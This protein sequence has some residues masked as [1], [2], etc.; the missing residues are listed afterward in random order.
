MPSARP[1]AVS[2]EFGQTVAEIR[3]DDEPVHDDRDIVRDVLLQRR[4]FVDFVHLAVDLDALETALLKVE[5]FL[6]VLALA[7][8]RDRGQQIEPRPSGIAMTR[9]TICDTVWLTI[10]SPVAGEYG[11]PTRAH[12][13]RM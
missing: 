12:S 1:S 10:G 11:T 8:A 13:S 5:E 4:D 7:A 6:A 9:S 3:P 2:N